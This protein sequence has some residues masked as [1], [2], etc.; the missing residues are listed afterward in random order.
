M[1]KAEELLRSKGSAFERLD[2][3]SDYLRF[4]LD[5]GQALAEVSRIF[6]FVGHALMQL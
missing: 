6:P 3:G 1:L 2:S 4:L 5:F